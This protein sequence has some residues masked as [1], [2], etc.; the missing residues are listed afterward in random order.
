MIV[1]AI[2]VIARFFN[3][4]RIRANT[5]FGNTQRRANTRFAPTGRDDNS[6]EMVGHDHIFIPFPRNL[7]NIDRQNKLSYKMY[8]KTEYRSYL[9][10]H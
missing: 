2:L 6:V 7:A 5:R 8:Y 10:L 3:G 1:G 9:C 4:N